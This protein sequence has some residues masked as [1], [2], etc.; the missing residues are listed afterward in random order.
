MIRLA[1]LRHG[2]TAWNRAG[3]IQGRTD[4]PLDGAA[5]AELAGLRLPAPWDAAR[6]VASPLM[7][8]RATARLVSGRDPVTD[9]ALVEMNWG[10][11]E[12]MHGADLL[13][14]PASGFRDI[15]DWGWTYTPPNGE[16][17]TDLRDRLL[18]WVHGQTRDTVV[19]SHIGVMRVLMA[20]AT[21][22]DFHG[23]APFR[24]KRNRLFIIEVTGQKLHLLPDPLRLEVMAR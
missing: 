18:P 14:D 5:V 19:V 17:L 4:V 21:G 7:R 8:A 2:H 11:W 10:D 16:S 6:L 23:P 3:R 12:G 22:W 13:A 15:S 9:A 1:L 20:M 24:I